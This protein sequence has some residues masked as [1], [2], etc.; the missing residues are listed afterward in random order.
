M[1]KQSQRIFAGAGLLA[2]AGLVAKILSAVY[3]VPFQ[4]IVGNQGFYVY[5][6]VYPIYGIGMVM[7]LSGWPLFISKMVAE[8]GSLQEQQ[9]V[10]KRLFWLLMGLSVLIFTAIY[11]GANLIATGMHD[12]RLIPE[13][14]AVAWMFLC[15]PFLAVG[16][17]YTQ[18]QLDMAP[19]A[20]SQVIEQVVRVGII[21][22]VAWWGMQQQWNVYQIGTWATFAATLAGIAAIISLWPK[23]GTVRS[24]SVSQ[25]GNIPVAWRTLWRRLWFEGG[26][27]AVLA[28]LLVLLQLIDSFTV[29]GLL[30]VN[31]L[32]ASAAEVQKG[33]Y[34]RGQPLVQ[35]GMVV[36]TG[37]GTALLPALHE[38]WQNKRWQELKKTF[39]MTVRISLVFSVLTAAGLITVL[40]V[41]NEMLFSSRQ[42]DSALAWYTLIVVPATLITV[43]TNV[44]QSLN[45]TKGLFWL[46]GVSLIIKWGLNQFLIPNFGIIGAAVAT[47]LALVPL[48]VFTIYR[49]PSQLWHKMSSKGWW[50]S[51]GLTTITVVLSAGVIRVVGD[52]LLGKGRL[53]SV[54][55]TVFAVVGGGAIGIILLLYLKIF[56]ED[57]L[58]A[59]P[60]GDRLVNRIKENKDAPR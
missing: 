6:Q 11:G 2:L 28:A 30:Q 32:S 25:T 39:Q 13:I 19:T 14:K 38:H 45:K 37:L 60:K 9:Q 22:V 15:M 26:L 4:N 55:T 42:G 52:T 56:N 29:K 46:V 50:L 33:V 12:V 35:L 31:G 34:D 8:Q 58:L 54:V 41:V 49:I 21:L 10:A 18:G 17:G 24:N 47:L 20:V 7:A 40:P 16:R 36:A 23:T 27:L 44:L 3:R 48:L 53:D 59:L 43:L 5:Q 57:E 1:A 51:L